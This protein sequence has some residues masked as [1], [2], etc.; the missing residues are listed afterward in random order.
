MI[1]V[2]LGTQDKSFKRLLEMID[3]EVKNKNI[4]DEI[5]VQAGFTKYESPNMKISDY[6]PKDEMDKLYKDCD[7]LITHGGIGSIL[8]G[9][10]NNKKVIA[11]ARLAKFKE[12]TNDHQLQIINNFTKAGYILSTQDDLAS[13]LNDLKKFKPKEYASTGKIAAIVEKYIKESNL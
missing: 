1:L 3:K 5:I 9:V 10:R 4:K 8:G 7:L 13:C 6:I 2:T 12:H 11:V